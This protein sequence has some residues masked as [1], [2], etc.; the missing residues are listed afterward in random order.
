MEQARGETYECGHR[1]AGV[2]V[3]NEG[4]SRMS[5]DAGNIMQDG[6]DSSAVQIG[7]DATGIEAFVCFVKATGAKVVQLQQQECSAR[8][9]AE[10]WERWHAPEIVTT[11]QLLKDY[12][13]MQESNRTKWNPT[14][15]H[16]RLIGT[17]PVWTLDDV[18]SDEIA[19]MRR[20]GMNPF[21]IV[22]TSEGNFQAWIKLLSAMDYLAFQDWHLIHHYIRAKYKADNGAGGVGHAFRLPLPGAYSHKRAVP[23]RMSVTVKDTEPVMSV[24][25]VLSQIPRAEKERNIVYADRNFAFLENW[26]VEEAEVPGWFREKWERRRSA[27]LASSACPLKTDGTTPDWSSVDYRA[28]SALLYGYK[29]RSKEQ[30]EHVV[31]WLANIVSDE[32]AKRGKPRPAQ[33]ALRTVNKVANQLGLAAVRD[34]SARQVHEQVVLSQLYDR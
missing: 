12:R 6:T 34:V 3:E 13:A 21:T 33:Y 26:G 8:G 32:A 30:Q 20:D 16:I 23:F 11:E 27:L 10:V 14:D 4:G 25:E 17:P 1:A 7:R 19:Q 29:N 22:E 5:K 28:A 24:S 15:W 18:S 31:S 2:I 9:G